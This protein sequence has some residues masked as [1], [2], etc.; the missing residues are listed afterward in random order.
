MR[1]HPFTLL[2][3]LTVIVIIAVLAGILLGGL[4]YASRRA[5]EAKTLAIMEDFATALEAFRVDYGFY[6]IQRPTSGDPKGDNL[7]VDFHDSVWDVF[8]NRDTLPE[9]NKKNRA[10]MEGTT[11]A[12]EDELLDAYG[13]ALYYRC[14][15]LRNP[16]KYDLWSKGP[17]AT[18]GEKKDNTS[19]NLGSDVPISSYMPGN[20][21]DICNW[22]KR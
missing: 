6:P 5:D 14:P 20:G 1:K 21:D 8:V 19:G 22:K 2:E 18:H 17:D 9:P 4:N 7:K 3:L 11:D 13:N 15:G 16:Q 10:Y 12:S